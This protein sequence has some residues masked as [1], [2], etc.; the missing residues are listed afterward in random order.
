MVTH[1]LLHR[2]ACQ[3]SGA[4]STSP[5]QSRGHLEGHQ[6]EVRDATSRAV[7]HMSHFLSTSASDRWTFTLSRLHAMYVCL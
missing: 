6:Q 5:G 3:L 2:F 7:S 1:N 4:S